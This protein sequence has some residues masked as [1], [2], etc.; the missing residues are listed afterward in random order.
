[1][2]AVSETFIVHFVLRETC[3]MCYSS[4]FQHIYIGHRPSKAWPKPSY[5][6]TYV[7]AFKK[8]DNFCQGI[9]PKILVAFLPAFF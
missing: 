2:S 3:I 4:S 7:Q 9:E 5:G 1:M 8:A 6:I